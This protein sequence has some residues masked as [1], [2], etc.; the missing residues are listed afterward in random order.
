MKAIPWIVMFI[1][2]W[3]VGFTWYAV[4]AVHWGFVTLAVPMTGLAVAIGIM[5]FSKE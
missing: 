1:A 3:M 5:L 2:V 4:F